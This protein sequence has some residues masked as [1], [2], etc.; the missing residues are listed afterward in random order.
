MSVHSDVKRRTIPELM[1]FKGKQKIVA[2]TAYVAPIARQLDP[3]MDIILV[4]DST[5]MVGYAM[6]DTLSITVEQMAA[7]AKAVVRSTAQSCVVVDMPF[8]SFQES[9]Q[10]AFK[11]AAYMLSSSGASAVKIEGGEAL[12]DTTRF[13]VD[14]GVPV[15]AHVGL[16]PQYVN[17]MGGFKAQG[18]NE[19]AAER[20]YQDALAQQAAGA[21]GVVLEGIAEPLA[22]RITQALD[23]P[24]IGIG[25][26]P[27][28]D[29]QV[30]VTED[31]M[32]LGEGRIPKFAKPFADVGAVM[33]EAAAEYASS[34]RDGTFPTLD[35][36]FGVKR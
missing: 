6:D 32:G 22:R 28:C 10:V 2:L 16:M 8:G 15:L 13:L 5:A 18:M 33:R 12:A 29:G 24:T 27:E 26:S 17:T 20:I 4:G 9:P 11:N 7:H 14:R 25:A 34:V 23:I 36:C 31:I 1:A 19:A 30:L 3:Y 35:Q 21:F